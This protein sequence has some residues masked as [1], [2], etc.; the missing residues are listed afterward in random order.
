[1]TK[2]GERALTFGLGL[3]ITVGTIIYVLYTSSGLALLPVALVKS[4]PSISAPG[5]AQNTA[6]QLEE[7]RERQRQ[8]EARNE[9]RQ[10]GPDSRD[11]RELEALIREERTLVRR[12]RLA[13]EAQG[14][15]RSWIVK[16]W[17]KVEAVFRPIKLLGGF[18]LMII[19]LLIWT[20]MLI[21]GIDKVKNSVCGVKCGYVLGKNHIF[22]PVNWIMVL[23]S[24]V[25]PID[26]V[27]FLLLFMFLFASSVV[28]IA[29]VGIRFLWVM[30]F[31]IRKGHTSPQALLMA[32][33]LLTLIVLALNYSVAMMIAPQYST[34]G[35]QRYCDRPP[36][37]PGE[38][39]DCSRHHSAI[40][41]CSELAD[42]PAAWDVCTPSVV[43]TFINRITINFP[44]FGV[45]LY[46]AQYVFLGKSEYSVFSFAKF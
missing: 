36:R 46:W 3:L 31:K 42:N 17:H 35:S 21:T 16:A 40:K 4:A 14:E 33:V 24:K 20:S 23:S 13:A 34:F 41:R 11:R 26:Y 6:S 10:N 19:A 29:V 12:E 32:T 8:L 2:D 39:P 25:F 7:N 28:G 22:Q 38:Q 27:I 30:I 44:F 9:G 5:L 15:G 18:L 45:I 1:M 43:S 37:H